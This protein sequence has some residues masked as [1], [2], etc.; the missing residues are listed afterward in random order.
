MPA[1]IS[2]ARHTGAVADAVLGLP[3]GIMPWGSRLGMHLREVFTGDTEQE[4]NSASASLR[5]DLT[6]TLFNF[7]DSDIQID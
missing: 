1:L 5:R 3:G 4:N 2:K 7:S 6:V